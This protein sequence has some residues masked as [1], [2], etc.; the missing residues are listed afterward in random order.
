MKIDTGKI[1][2]CTINRLT[3]AKINQKRLVQ[4]ESAKF[5]KEN[6][7]IFKKISIYVKGAIF[8][9]LLSDKN[10]FNIGAEQVTLKSE[11]LYK[12]PIP[13]RISASVLESKRKIR[14]PHF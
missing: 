13:V 5:T 11:L 14:T 8:L 6:A 10:V 1:S 7:F 3:Q 2:I 12:F 9:S 4:T